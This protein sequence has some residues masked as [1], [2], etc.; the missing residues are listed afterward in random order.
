MNAINPLSTKK[1]IIVMR[2]GGYPTH[3][4]RGIDPSHNS[5]MELEAGS[6]FR[7][8]LAFSLNLM[9]SFCQVQ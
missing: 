4:K 1:L 2:G 5:Y 3:V 7:L 6:F 9:N 8:N